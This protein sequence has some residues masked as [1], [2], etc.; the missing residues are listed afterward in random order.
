MN[1]KILSNEEM[2]KRVMCENDSSMCYIMFKTDQLPVQR[3][4]ILKD[5]RSR[6][7]CPSTVSIYSVP[8]FNY[9]M[10]CKNIQPSG[11]GISLNTI[12]ISSICALFSII[13]YPMV[14]G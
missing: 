3:L 14:F 13:A 7:I 9:G 1:E 5:G 12:F 8:Y 10:A 2:A 6:W 11:A 4:D